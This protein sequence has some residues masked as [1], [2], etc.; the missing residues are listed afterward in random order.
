MK[1]SVRVL[2]VDDERIMRDSLSDWLKEDGYNVVAV[3]SGAEAIEK[4][5]TEEWDVLIADLK[6]PGMDGIEVMREVGKIDKSLPVIIMTAYA[7][8]DTAVTAMK[9]GAYDYIAKPFNPEEVGLTIRKIV[10]Q[11]RLIEENIYLRQELRRRYEFKDIITKNPKMRSILDL[12]RSVAKTTSTVLIEGES[13]TGKELVARAV[14]SCSPRSMGPFVAV[15]CAAL[16]ETLL[17]TELYGHEKGAFT[18]AVAAK[19]GRFQLA[20]KGTLFLDEIGEI[21]LKTQVNLLRVLE[22][23]E[24]TRVGGTK[25]EKVD[26]RI[27]SAT[28]KNLMELVAGGEFR[29]DLYYRLKVVSINLPPLR[30]RKEDIPLLVECFLEKYRIEHEKKVRSISQEAMNVF[31][32]YGWPGNIR[33]LENIIE[34]AVVTT[35]ED[36][37]GVVDLPETLTQ[38]GE[39][40]HRFSADNSLSDVEREHIR[41]VLDANKWNVK[42]SAETLGIDRTTLYSKMR[43]Y[44]FK[45]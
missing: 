42:K 22:Q 18:G 40:V 16:P 35:K 8:V 20:H 10:T 12:V 26:V 19:K 44:G 23:K 29:D 2:V 4:V 21:S 11:Q 5:K 25:S 37:I 7:T 30:E 15:S 1:E 33:E 43:K 28:N 39:K 17:E 41:S 38:K 6:M 24:V 3:G 31:L 45:K 9:E 13:G 27:I 14:H 34:S 36:A 32:K